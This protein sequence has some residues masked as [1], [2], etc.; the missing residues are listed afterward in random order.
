MLLSEKTTG[1]ERLKFALF[2]ILTESLTNLVSHASQSWCFHPKLVCHWKV[3]MPI[4]AIFCP[5]WMRPE[6]AL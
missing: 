1:F 2:A 6:F 3:A 4:T 5:V